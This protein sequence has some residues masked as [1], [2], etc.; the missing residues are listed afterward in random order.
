MRIETNPN[1]ET[2]SVDEVY[3][4]SCLDADNMMFKRVPCVMGCQRGVAHQ[5]NRLEHQ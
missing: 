2:A 5:G 3:Y 1:T 4:A